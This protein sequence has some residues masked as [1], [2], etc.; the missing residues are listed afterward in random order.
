MK[1]LE[2]HPLTADRWQDFERLFGLREACV[3]CCD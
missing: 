1:P 2:V 3:T